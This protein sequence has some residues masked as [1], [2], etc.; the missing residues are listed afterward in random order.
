MLQVLEILKEK[1]P[2]IF[3]DFEIYE[4]ADGSR[5]ARTRYQFS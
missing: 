1:A 2:A 3:A 4:M 5:A